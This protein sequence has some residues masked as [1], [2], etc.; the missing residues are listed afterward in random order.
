MKDQKKSNE[1]KHEAL[2]I[3]NEG[4]A[5]AV[6]LVN[7]IIDQ[8]IEKRASDIHLEPCQEDLKVRFRIDGLLY[9][10]MVLAKDVMLTL[11]SRIPEQSR[12]TL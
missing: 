2:M 11:I 4:D 10:I 12:K 1:K 3:K 6:Q 5:S 8:A 9:E 7:E